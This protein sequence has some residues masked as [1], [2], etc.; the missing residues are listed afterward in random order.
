MAAHPRPISHISIGVRSYAVSKAF[1]A[2]VLGP[3]G[4]L[5]VYDSETTSLSPAT[6]SSPPSSKRRT[7]G[8]GPDADHEMVNIFEVGE[9]AAA[10]GPGCHVA[11][12]APTRAAVREFYEQAIR[13][14][15]TGDGEPALRRYYEPRYYA[16]FVIDPDGWR[17]EAVCK[18]DTEAGGLTPTIQA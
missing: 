11:F 2:A 6:S 7:L 16:A 10:P 9:H 15:G 1:Y 8:F 5:L 4:L 3:L 12:N 18:A 14:G 13:L 17:L